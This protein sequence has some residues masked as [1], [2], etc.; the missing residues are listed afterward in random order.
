VDFLLGMDDHHLHF[1]ECIIVSYRGRVE[2]DKRH[3]LPLSHPSTFPEN[4]AHCLILSLSLFHSHPP[5]PINI[6]N[7]HPNPNLIRE[8]VQIKHNKFPVYE[9]FP[10][11]PRSSFHS[12]VRSWTASRVGKCLTLSPN[13]LTASYHLV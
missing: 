10:S 13:L 4:S 7:L 6:A 12:L 5:H 1:V 9:F 8:V 3:L 2:C 11:R